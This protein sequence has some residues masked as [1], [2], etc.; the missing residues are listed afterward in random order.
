MKPVNTE[1]RKQ[2]KARATDTPSA[3]VLFSRLSVR[4]E[5]K[6]AASWWAVQDCRRVQR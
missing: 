1:S 2:F 5:Y 4:K 6:A 3:A